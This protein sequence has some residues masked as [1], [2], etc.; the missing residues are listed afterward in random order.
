MECMCGTRP[1]IEAIGDAI[2]VILAVDREVSTLRQIL[3]QQ[4]V[5]VLAGATLPGAVGVAEIDPHAG[6]GSEFLVAR[7][8]LALVI[9]EGLSQWCGD[10]VELGG[11]ARE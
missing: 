5:G 10:G 11:E 1:A 4:A 2:K 9:R 8:F 7:H 3:A 6:S